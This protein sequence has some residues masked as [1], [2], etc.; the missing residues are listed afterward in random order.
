M[1]D[2]MIGQL[3]NVPYRGIK[4]QSALSCNEED[5]FEELKE[6][7]EDACD[8]NQVEENGRRRMCYELG[9]IERTGTA[10]LFL[11]AIKL[12][13]CNAFSATMG[14]E[15]CS[16]VNWLLGITTVNPL[17]YHL[18]FE[19]FFHKK[20]EYLPTFTVYTEKGGRVSILKNL[21]EKYGEDIVI[22]GYDDEESFYVSSKPID[23]S[24]IKE[25]RVIKTKKA[26]SER[27]NEDGRK[28]F[29]YFYRVM[30][31]AVSKAYVIATLYNLI[32]CKEEEW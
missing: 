29:D 7:L 3:N 18:P 14:I 4:E 9:I 31:Y 26:I 24:L 23:K 2:R 20:K 17:L 25:R 22:R 27:Y 16:Y 19:R 10:K 8:F 30:P 15:G 5:S 11:F 21:C 13:Y 12:M 6:L 28:L 32:D 1:A